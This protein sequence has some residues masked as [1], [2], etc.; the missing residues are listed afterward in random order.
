MKVYSP[1]SEH[2][3]SSTGGDQD[4]YS[5]ASERLS[6]STGGD[7]DTYSPAASAAKDGGGKDFSPADDESELTALTATSCSYA[8]ACG[9]GRADGAIVRERDVMVIS[10]LP[11]AGCS[12]GNGYFDQARCQGHSQPW[13]H[14][15]HHLTPSQEPHDSHLGVFSGILQLPI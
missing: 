15:V 3:P 2:P 8:S 11:R 4:I 1:A 10:E 5:P 12:M 13:K 6:S 14:S 9:S 7:Q